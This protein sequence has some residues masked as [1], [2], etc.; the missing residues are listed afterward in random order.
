MIASKDSQTELPSGIAI[1]FGGT[2]I[3]ASKILKGEIIKN[4]QVLTEKD[5]DIDDHIASISQLIENLEISDTDK[6]GVA[7]TGRI[8]ES[9]DWHSVND[10]TLVK[11]KSIPLQKKLSEKFKRNVKV[12]NDAIAAASGEYIAGSGKGFSN[13]GSQQALKVFSSSKRL[14]SGSTHCELIKS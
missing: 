1:D 6:I 7:V 8:D 4:I 2:K 14:V 13:I 5:S 10:T 3:S 11:I 12:M 9:G